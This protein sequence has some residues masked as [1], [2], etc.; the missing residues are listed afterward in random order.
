MPYFRMYLSSK[1]THPELET[2]GIQSGKQPPLSKQSFRSQGR[3]STPI[4]DQEKL[5]TDSVPFVPGDPRLHLFFKTLPRPPLKVINQ[6]ES[7]RKN[8]SPA[9]HCSH[10]NQ[11]QKMDQSVNRKTV[12]LSFVR[13]AG[14]QNSQ[15]MKSVNRNFLEGNECFFNL[16]MSV[17]LIFSLKSLSFLLTI[18]KS[19]LQKIKGKKTI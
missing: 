19:V 15:L 6:E 2:K 11:G 18:Q 9:L 1:E 17:F 13:G 7:K 5:Q 12:R 3:P 16:V 4:P 10:H 8:R 14:S